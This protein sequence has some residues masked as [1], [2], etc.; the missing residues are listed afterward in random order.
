[1]P[2]SPDLLVGDAERASAATEL[3][4]HYDSGR[5]TLDEFEE[6]LAQ[7]HAARTQSD[8]REAFRQLPAKLPTLKPRDRRWRS[9]ATQYVVVNLVAI[10]IW[11]VTGANGSFWPKW[12]FVVTLF[13]FLRRVMRPS[14]AHRG[15]ELPPPGPP[16]LPGS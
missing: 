1:M 8:L 6:R 14:R 9:L 15:R 3:R 4:E 7:V 12:V 2:D 13:M 10:A 5:L 11:L 16:E